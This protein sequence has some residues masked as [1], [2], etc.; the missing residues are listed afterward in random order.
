[1]YTESRKTSMIDSESNME[2]ILHK[3]SLKRYDAPGLWHNQ[4]LDS[5]VNQVDEGVFRPLFSDKMGAPNIPIRQLIGINILKEGFGISDEQMFDQVQFHLLVRKALGITQ[6]D[7]PGPSIE[8][9]YLFRRR[10]AEY[11]METGIDLYKLCFEAITKSQVLKY[12]VEGKSIRMD[13][14]LIGSNIASYS[15]F[16]IVHETIFMSAKHLSVKQLH[17]LKKEDRATFGTL[18]AEPAQQLVYTETTESIEKRLS[19]LGYLMF[20]LLKHFPNALPH[21]NL[22]KRV[23]NE[24]F[25]V[26]KK[27][28][29]PR[30]KKDIS[31][32]SVQNPH[33]PDATYRRKEDQIVKGFITNIAETC[34]KEGLNLITNVQVE[35]VSAP[36]NGFLESAI[37]DSQENVLSVDIENV[38]ADGAYHSVDNQAFATKEEIELYLTGMQ[39]KPPRY[40]LLLTEK[41]LQVTDTQT[42]EVQ[43][44]YVTKN[45]SWRIKTEKGY[46]YFTQKDIDAAALRKELKDIPSEIK[47]IRNNVEAAMFQYSFHSRNNK[48]RYRGLIKHKMFAFARCLWM[49]LVRITN[50]EIKI[51]QGAL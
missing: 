2:N 39:G 31:A 51:C 26:D 17:C 1:M 45:G 28:V 24:Q 16:Q 37:T 50:Y 5:V 4:F 8:V 14:K 10:I 7:D 13:S 12:K 43:F 21:Y 44:A 22:L 29:T 48:T 47:K 3:R 46:R 40:T 33:D 23:F 35:N 27:T 9:Y 41:G 49:N 32:K 38:H 6:M 18:M 20:G 11:E 42:S 25:I 15:R 36:D 30:N 19:D 34:D